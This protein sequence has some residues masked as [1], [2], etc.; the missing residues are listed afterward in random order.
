MKEGGLNNSFKELAS[1]ATKDMS[2]YKS[3]A[4]FL[5]AKMQNDSEKQTN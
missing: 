4:D 2:D 3:F 1:Q 5:N